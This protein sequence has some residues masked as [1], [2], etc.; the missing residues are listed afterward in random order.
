MNYKTDDELF[1]M[2]KTELFTSVV[3]DVM[4]Q[5]GLA[6]QFLPRQIRP[7]RDDM[8]VAGRAM[9]VLEADCKGTKDYYENKEKPFG[10]MLEALD[11]L[12]KNDVYICTGASDTYACWGELMSTRARH[13]E[14]AGAVMEGCS[15]DSAGIFRLNFPTFSFGPYGQDQGIRGRVIDFNCPIEFSN[16]V[17]VNPGDIVFGDYEGVLIVPK[18][19]EEAIIQ[20]A[21][22]KVRNENKVRTAIEQGMPTREAWDRFGVM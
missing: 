22:E 15:R 9:P 19:R 21:L 6:H 11:S 13:L 18:E 14:A 5:M 1:S 2:M 20:A 7:L 8:I 16:Q 10:I 12:K 3:G 17:A 4:D